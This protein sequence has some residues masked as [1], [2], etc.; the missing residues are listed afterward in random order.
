MATGAPPEALAQAAQHFAAALAALAPYWSPPPAATAAPP[1]PAVEPL[2]DRREL[3][4][5]LSVSI[6]TVD[7]LDR[8]GQ[9]HVRVGDSKR[10]HVAEV[11]RWHRERTPAEAPAVA[12]PAQVATPAA[13]SRGGVRV[14]SRPRRA[15][16]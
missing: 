5:L 15:A 3:A 7:R 6:A 13:T 4:R 9:P 14:L 16:T 1:A 12:S 10:Y 2:V 11:L 8:E